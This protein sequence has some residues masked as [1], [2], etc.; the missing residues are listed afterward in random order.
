MNEELR[1][2]AHLYSRAG[3]GIHPL[4]LER[5][6]GK[7]K[8]DAIA[9]V[10]KLLKSPKNLQY[11]SDP[12]PAKA[13][14]SSFR[15]VKLILKSR[16][17]LRELNL[18]WIKRMSI[19]EDILREKMTLFWHDHF[20]C[21]VPFA[22]LMQIQNNTL[23]QHALGNFKDILLAMA[24]DPA[25][26][27]F[28]NNQQN[29]KAKPNEN[30][31]RE[32]MELFTLGPGNY[33]EHDI[34]EAARAFTGWQLD[35]RGDFEF[36]ADQHD[37]GHKSFLG[38]EGDFDGEGLLD[39]ILKQKACAQFLCEKMY[40]F[41]VNDTEVDKA[42]VN[43]LADEFR[44]SN[45]DIR[46]LMLLIFSSSWFFD[47]KNIAA[48]IKSPVELLVQ[49]MKLVNIKTQNKEAILKLQE[50]LGQVLFF[51]PNVAGWPGGKYWIDSSSLLVRMKLPLAFFSD[52][53]LMLSSKV[54]FEESEKAITTRE[55]FSLKMTSDWKYLNE[56]FLIYSDDELPLQIY[57]S[58]ILH[59]ATNAPIDFVKLNTTGISKVERIKMMVLNVMVLPEFQLA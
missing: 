26:I 49:F 20:A 17:E 25:M 22:Y 33:T 36:N 8:E 53:R 3:F 1:R 14:V 10:F 47:E 19:T 4:E 57:E 32:L 30:F 28:L 31:A 59:R 2:I 16:Q 9:R 5:L 18:A 51:P 45:Y 29:L 24:K 37:F 44:A 35:K 40:R 58:L 12:R 50:S 27:L 43:A 21:N 41:F 7:S 46:H 56:S 23:R 15:T 48:K 52:E 42:I 11:L 13:E 6:K 55:D 54:T 38:Q 34:K 39:V